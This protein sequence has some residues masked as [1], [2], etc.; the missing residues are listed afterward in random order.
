M[1]FTIRFGMAALLMMSLAERPSRAAS[2]ECPVVG[3]AYSGCCETSCSDW[4]VDSF[5]VDQFCAGRQQT[6]YDTTCCCQCYSGPHAGFS[7][8]HSPEEPDLDC[9]P[10]ECCEP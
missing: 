10:L 5:P 8:G 6:G 2:A 4:C 9:P 1:K 3:Q 7:C